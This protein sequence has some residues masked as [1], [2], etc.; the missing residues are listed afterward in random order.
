MARVRVF[1][2]QQ[3]SIQN[4]SETLAEY[5]KKQNESSDNK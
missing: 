4:I 5:V 1:Q 3:Q 2:K